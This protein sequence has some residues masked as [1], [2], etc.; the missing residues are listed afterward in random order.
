MLGNSRLGKSLS[1]FGGAKQREEVKSGIY[2]IVENG[3][4][5]IK[6]IAFNESI[7]D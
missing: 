7:D 1:E 2:K 3:L 6:L 4:T 5:D